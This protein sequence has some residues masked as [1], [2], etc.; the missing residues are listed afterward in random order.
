MD[1]WCDDLWSY[2]KSRISYGEAKRVWGP[3]GVF[4][5]L[6]KSQE[7]L[8]MRVLEN[9]ENEIK[10][11]TNLRGGPAPK[12]SKE[13]SRRTSHILIFL[14]APQLKSLWSSA[15]QRPDIFP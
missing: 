4:P 7:F 1:P 11:E 8:A 14:S 12:E 15:Q 10:G 5:F 13:V 3:T 6:E 9:V 2:K